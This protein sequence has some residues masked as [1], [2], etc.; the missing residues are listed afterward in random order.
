MLALAVMR[1]T[2][3]LTG[4]YDPQKAIPL[5]E[6]ACELTERRQPDPLTILARAYAL[7]G[8]NLDAFRTADEALRIARAAGD[9]GLA[10]QIEKNRAEYERSASQGKAGSP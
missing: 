3:G 5:A 4:W 7:G 2:P 8:R 10:R 9:E 1:M 6:K